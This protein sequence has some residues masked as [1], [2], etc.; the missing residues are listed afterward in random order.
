MTAMKADKVYEIAEPHIPNWLDIARETMF[1]L[2][3]PPEYKAHGC[4]GLDDVANIA[5]EK[6]VEAIENA[7]VP[8]SADKVVD[9]EIKEAEDVIPVMVEEEFPGLVDDTS[10]EL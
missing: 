10:I 5:T 9:E 3:S 1:N 7:P 4:N 6:A 2:S 8:S